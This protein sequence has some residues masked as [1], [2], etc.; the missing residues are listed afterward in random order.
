MKNQK[1]VI[2]FED[3]CIKENLKFN[4]EHE[5][6]SWVGAINEASLSRIIRKIKIDREDFAVLTAERGELPRQENI[7]RNSIL[8]K[9]LNQLKMGPYLL[10]GHWQE[11][12]KGM[13]WE[14]VKRDNPELLVD[15]K[16][17]S[18]LFTRKSEMPV[19]DFKELV[20]DI[21]N[22]WEQDSAVLSLNDE[23]FLIFRNGNMKSLG[24]NVTLEK[25]GD[26]YSIMKKGNADIPFLFEGSRQPT[27]NSSRHVFKV[28]GLEYVRGM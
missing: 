26:A 23:A 16:E 12:P 14:V 10:D 25:I 11:A 19:E 20:I 13:D 24:K 1:A 2:S 3:F 27:S 17:N 4:E 6:I 28:I 18:F 22:K 15:K 8:L 7:K 21:I 5:E 9:Q